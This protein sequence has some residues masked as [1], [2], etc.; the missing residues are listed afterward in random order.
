MFIFVFKK[1]L[2][3]YLSITIC[4][5]TDMLMEYS[6]LVVEDE[7][8]SPRGGGGGGKKMMSWKCWKKSQKPGWGYAK[9][10]NVAG[11]RDKKA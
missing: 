10:Q 4:I 8:Q 3:M 2:S 1:A 6:L 5:H 11:I 9:V 7:T